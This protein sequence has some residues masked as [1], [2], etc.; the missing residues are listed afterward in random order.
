MIAGNGSGDYI[1]NVAEPVTNHFEPIWGRTTGMNVQKKL[2]VML[3]G[4]LALGAMLSACS[5]SSTTENTAT[6]GT[7]AQQSGQPSKD[8]GK[9]TEISIMTTYYTPEPPG[10]DNPVLKEIENRTN[11]KLK[12]T[13][14]SPNNYNDKANVTLASGDIPDMMLILD[15]FHPQ[16]R[17]M[18]VQ[19]AFWDL[20]ALYKNYPNLAKY[21]QD[22]WNNLKQADGKN[23]GVPRVRPVEG[24]LFPYIRKDWLDKLGMKAPATMDELYTVMKAF[25]EKDPDGNGKADTMGLS[26]YVNIDNMG[27]LGWVQAVFNKTTGGWKQDNGKLTS[28]DL[29][30]ET[31][32]ALIWLNQAYKEKLIPEDFSVMKH[33]Q[34][35]DLV[36]SGKAGAFA[37]TVEAAWEPTAALRKT[38]PEADYLPLTSLNGYTARE[39]GSFGMYMI[40]KS[41]SEAKMKKILEFLNYGSSDEG[42]ELGNF[43]LKDT[44]YALDNGVY[45]TTEIHAKQ[46]IGAFGQLFAKYDKYHRAYRA[47]IP[48]DVWE[49]NKKI[50][51]EREKVSVPDYAIGL[52]S[53]TSLKVGPELNKKIQDMKTKVIMGKEPI[54]AWD[55]FVGKLKTDANFVKITNEL[56]DSY[57]KRSVE[58]K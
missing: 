39:M 20:S 51:D 6:P 4:T 44:H 14:V 23:Y 28:V 30:P 40:P 13:W 12:I 22:T 43:G 35:K 17:S 52:F 36:I 7:S 37:D 48:K 5:S 16:V 32:E 10:D 49:R 46:S 15:V 27:Y 54:T 55:D 8:Q 56:N 42:H 9:P 31:R 58:S 29:T 3:T 41:V 53:E 18:T 2:S 21:P 50:I 34:A 19:G 57:K 26:G 47:G 33:T 45:K 24:G 38:I 1:E 25:T 11:T